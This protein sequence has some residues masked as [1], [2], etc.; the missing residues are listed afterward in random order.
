M[1][2]LFKNLERKQREWNEWNVH[3]LPL[4][5]RARWGL[6]GKRKENGPIKQRH[7]LYF[8]LWHWTKTFYTWWKQKHSLKHWIIR[9]NLP[10]AHSSNI[11]NNRQQQCLTLIRCSGSCC[12]V[13]WAYRFP[14][15]EHSRM[16]N[17]NMLVLW[18]DTGGRAAGAQAPYGGS[19]NL[20]FLPALPLSILQGELQ[21]AWRLQVG[22]L[23]CALSPL[24]CLVLS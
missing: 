21:R 15:R 9:W 2:N 8:F 16:R 24:F 6:E 18:L 19:G 5:S 11:F 20:L 23:T 22:L 7:Y 1:F 12:I 3:T 4:Y 14:C 10:P 17:L 13:R